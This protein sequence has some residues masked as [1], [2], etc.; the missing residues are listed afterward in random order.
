MEAL[1]GDAGKA[2]RKLGWT[3]ATTLAELVS[4]MVDS[5]Y[6]AAKRDSLVKRAGFQAPDY[7]E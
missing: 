5:D 7:H 2:K 6:L 1:L 4:E 3:P